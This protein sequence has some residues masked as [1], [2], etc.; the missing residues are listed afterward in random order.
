MPNNNLSKENEEVAENKGCGDENIFFDEAQ[1]IIIAVL[2]ALPGAH[3]IDELS[4]ACGLKPLEARQKLEKMTDLLK[5]LKSPILIND[6]NDKY[7]LCSNP[8]YFDY[9]IKVVSSP[10]KPELTDVMLETLAIIAEKKSTTKVEIENIRGVKSDF[11]VNKLLEYGLIEEKG[12][13]SA[14]GR[15]I[16][17]GPSDEFYRRFGINKENPIPKADDEIIKETILEVNNVEGDI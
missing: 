9:L 4:K 11:A 1:K 14:P 15:P 6:I 3:T 16:V 17:F 5:R 10:V 13:L 2:F 12:R 7:E 8:L